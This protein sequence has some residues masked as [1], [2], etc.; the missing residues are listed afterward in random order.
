MNIYDVD[1]LDKIILNIQLLGSNPVI[2]YL[3][4]SWSVA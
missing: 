2:F 3:C 4:D 1:N